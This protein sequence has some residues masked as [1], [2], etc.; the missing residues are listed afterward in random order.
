MKN[1]YIGLFIAAIAMQNILAM[2]E[3]TVMQRMQRLQR[4]QQGEIART[5][6][7]MGQARPSQFAEKGQVNPFVGKHVHYELPVQKRTLVPIQSMTP[8]ERARLQSQ[9]I[10]SIRQ[11]PFKPQL[12]P[13]SPEEKTAAE[14]KRLAEAA[15][16]NRAQAQASVIP[17]TGTP[18]VPTPP[19]RTTPPPLPIGPKKIQHPPL[20]PIPTEPQRVDVQP[21][22][23][24]VLPQPNIIPPPPLPSAA[25]HRELGA[26]IEAQRRELAAKQTNKQLI[27]GSHPTQSATRKASNV[28]PP[29]PA[30][31]TTRPRGKS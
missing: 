22:L 29:L 21:I 11:E 7:Q 28:Q 17:T 20:P 27:E 3:E 31:P 25:A 24:P 16:R 13:A 6:Q 8:E 10:S 14:G 26:K 1:L 30:L 5:H 23:R 2:G 4:E 12:L 19:T 15:A 18:S 9:N